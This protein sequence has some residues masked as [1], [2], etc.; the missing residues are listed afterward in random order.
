MRRASF[1]LRNRHP[2]ILSKN[3]QTLKL[4]HDLFDEFSWSLPAAA[5]QINFRTLRR[6]VWG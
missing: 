5:V 2:T 6:L 1:A 3:V 4:P